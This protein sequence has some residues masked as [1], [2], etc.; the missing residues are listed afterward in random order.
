[1]QREMP[2]LKTIFDDII[3][4]SVDTQTYMSDLEESL[5]DYFEEVHEHIEENTSE[6]NER[7]SFIER[8]IIEFIDSYES[9]FITIPD[10]QEKL[11]FD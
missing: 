2:L 8:H 6:L 10:G 11:P 5:Q 7:L 1:M 3:D 4:Y 9:R